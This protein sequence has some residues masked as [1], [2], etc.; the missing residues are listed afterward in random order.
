MK[1]LFAIVALVLLAGCGLMP[2]TPAL[3]DSK[4]LPPIA[5][6][7]LKAIVAARGG[8]DAAYDFIGSGVRSGAIEPTQGRTWFN[9]L[10]TYRDK[11]NQAQKLFDTGGYDAAK[12]Q[13][14]GT[15]ALIKFI[16]DQAIEAL[17]K[18]AKPVGAADLRGILTDQY[19]IRCV[20]H[21][22][23]LTCVTEI[24]QPTSKEMTWTR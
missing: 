7:A 17:K 20:D 6:E 19:R 22:G 4:T 2:K 14:Q 13:A 11:V 5:N 21:L 15:E 24:A 16:H 18:Q 10:D 1:K 9:T 3:P 12:L 8:L 23:T